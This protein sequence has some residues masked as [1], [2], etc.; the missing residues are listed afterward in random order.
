MNYEIITLDKRIVV[1][2]P[3]ITNN[4]NGKAMV[5]IGNS[6]NKFVNEGVY[7]GITNKSNTKVM[8]L[9]YDY[10]G[11][12]TGDYHFMACCEVCNYDYGELTLIEI[13]KSKYAKFTFKGNMITDVAN[14]WEKIWSMPLDRKYEY[15]FEVYNKNSKDIS[16]QIIEIFIS[17]K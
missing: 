6:W 3:I 10:E 17:L 14:A 5:D 16:N 1:G 13:P 4:G 7:N 15:D 9:Y 12:M 11:D 2:N 8:G